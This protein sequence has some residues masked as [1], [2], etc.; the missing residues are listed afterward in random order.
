MFFGNSIKARLLKISLIA[1]VAALFLLKSVELVKE[2]DDYRRQILHNALTLTQLIGNNSAA[3]IS[4]KDIDAAYEVLSSMRPLSN[5]M[6]AILYDNSGKPFVSFSRHQDLTASWPAASSL[7]VVS[8]FHGLYLDVGQPII[9]KGQRIG[10]IYIRV[11]TTEQY[12][13]VLRSFGFA[14]SIILIVSV[15]TY[16]LISRLQRTITDRLSRLSA[17]TEDISNSQDYSLRAPLEPGIQVDEIQKLTLGFNDMLKQIQNREREL[18]K[19]SRAV[20]SSASAIMITDTAGIIQYV[21]PKFSA[22][23]EYTAEEAIGKPVSILKSGETSAQAYENMWRTLLSGEEWRGEYKNRRK[24]GQFYWCMEAVSVIKDE[25]GKVT[26]FVA[27]MEDVTDRKFA[28]ATIYRL[29]YYDPLTELPNRR[30]FMEKLSQA[31]LWNNRSDSLIALCYLDLDRFKDINDTLGH[32]VGDKLLKAI[33]QR[34]RLCLR[35][36]DTICRLGGDEFAILLLKVHNDKDITVVADKIMQSVKHPVL[37]E[38]HELYVT[39][40]IGISIYPADARNVDDLFRNAD[41]ALYY[42]KERGKNNYQFFSE[43]LNERNA[44]RVRLA[45]ALRRAIER[46]EFYLQY[47][48]KVNLSNGRICGAEALIRWLDPDRG[49]VAP[50]LFIP[51]AEETKLIIPIG[52]WLIAEA[53]IQ[54]QEWDRQGLPPAPIAI[55]LSPAQ[56]YKPGL[57]EYIQRT[58]SSAGLSPER[59]ELEIT[60]SALAENHELTTHMLHRLRGLGLKVFIDDFGTGYSS[61]SYLKHFPVSALKIDRSFICE[62][63][64][65]AYDRGIVSAVVAIANKL[66]L[67]V[68]AEGVETEE[69]LSALRELRCHLIQGFLISKPLD[70][71]EYLRFVRSWNFQDRTLRDGNRLPEVLSKCGSLVSK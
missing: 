50:D 5:V 11:E 36:M 59:L 19:L 47:Q 65:D 3:A 62:I 44:E 46:K 31:T 38:G 66:H 18:Q 14:V 1:T 9:V 24:S 26:H 39:T 70:P 4:F 57:V 32:N 15:L 56:F 43:E 52:E 2:F 35:S 6:F 45:G 20:Q 71:D 33:G 27:S 16:G 28:E 64:T 25:S 13:A 67:E 51:L 17:L 61:L 8:R 69:Q 7:Q 10:F 41:T 22:I 63:S 12:L 53:C 48:P 29:A 34:L 40:S 21:N 49:T 54:M 37:I 42:A 60:E 68:V 55:N 23:N 58:L 30:F